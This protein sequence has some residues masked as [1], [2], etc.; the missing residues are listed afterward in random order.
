MSIIYNI[1][2]FEEIGKEDI[3]EVVKKNDGNY[4]KDL[5]QCVIQKKDDAI[6]ISWEIGDEIPTGIYNAGHKKYGFYPKAIIYIQPD[7]GKSTWGNMYKFCLN[8][9]IE[10]NKSILVDESNV[11]YTLEDLKKVKIKKHRFIIK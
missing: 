9:L 7:L 2:V 6:I 5:D 10:Y 1:Y 11:K 3:V 4:M 8:F